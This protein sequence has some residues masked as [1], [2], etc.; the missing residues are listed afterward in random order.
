M[1]C[2]PSGNT[3]YCEWYRQVDVRIHSGCSIVYRLP[4]LNQSLLE[5]SRKRLFSFLTGT[6]RSASFYGS[7]FPNGSTNCILLNENRNSNL[8]NRENVQPASRRRK[9][10]DSGSPRSETQSRNN[11]YS[12]TG[13]E[14]ATV[15]VYVNDVGNGN[16]SNDADYNS[17]LVAAERELY[18]LIEAVLASVEEKGIES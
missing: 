17:A 6:G 10:K 8:S 4:I 12:D 9:R 2:G 18:V 1:V 13:N 15:T 14:E 5:G 11:L 3:K 7:L 16:D